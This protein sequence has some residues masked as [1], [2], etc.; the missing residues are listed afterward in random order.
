MPR[1]YVL[2]HL[3]FILTI[4]K[5]A[6]YAESGS[7]WKKIISYSALAVIA[8]AYAV[9][10]FRFMDT[11]MYIEA[12]YPVSALVFIFAAAKRTRWSRNAALTFYLLFIFGTLWNFIINLASTGSH[13]ASTYTAPAVLLL[14]ILIINHE[15][16]VRNGSGD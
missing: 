2:F 16:S 3:V 1:R 14:L 13:I 15:L 9:I 7:K 8:V 6:F 12:F 10:P 4:I 5:L 11:P